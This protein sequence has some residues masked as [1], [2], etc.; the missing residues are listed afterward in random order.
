MLVNEKKI[1]LFTIEGEVLDMKIDGPYDTAR[2]A[3][4]LGPQLNG[5][6]SVEVDLKSYLTMAKALN[7]V[8]DEE[9][10]F[11][12]TMIDGKEVQ[13]IFYPQKVQVS[14]KHEEKEVLIPKVEKLT[15]HMNRAAD[16]NSP[17]VRNFLRRLAPVAKNRLH[18]AEDLMDFIER[19]ELPLTNDGR[20][21]G[22][23]RVNR[24]GHKFVDCHSG[25][26]EQQLG[27]RVWMD[28]EKVDPSRTNSCSNGLHVANLGYLRS[29]GGTHTLI[30]LVDP[31]DFIAVPRGETNKCRVSSY[32][33]IGVMSARSQE[34]V[35]QGAHVEGD[36]TLESI[37]KAAVEGT[38]VQPFETIKVGDRCVLEHLPITEPLKD[39]IECETAGPDTKESSGKSLNTDQAQEVKEKD[40]L[41]M[42]K[43]A[44]ATSTGKNP[45]D[46]APAEVITVFE[47]MRAGIKSKSQI[48]ADNGTSTR[49]MGRWADKYD[50]EGYVK[51]KENT[52]NMT[53]AEKAQ[54]LFKQWKAAKTE[55][56]LNTLVMFKK[57]R[58]KGWASLGFSPSQERE[59]LKAISA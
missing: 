25:K 34:I 54:Y 18:S 20:I 12:T 2:L 17:A 24:S 1:T 33:I 22:Y 43:N 35:N 46:S 8:N 15:K 26:I 9:G 14:V 19:S 47:E 56:T 21:I 36:H 29:F 48:A 3:E 53:V 49:S 27:S 40:I 5:T 7:A 58:K 28:A 50:F 31:A 59:I 11:I 42:A 45:W 16:E 13:G 51:F 44:K 37:I 38:H 6:N 41:K 52:S 32:D 10:V 57:A 30:V 55:E 23:K 4:D 39:V